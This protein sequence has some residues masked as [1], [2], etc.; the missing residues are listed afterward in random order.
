[1]RALPV[2][3]LFTVLAPAALGAP[4]SAVPNPP[5]MIAH[6][7]EDEVCRSGRLQRDDKRAVPK[8]YLSKDETTKPVIVLPVDR[9][10]MACEGDEDAPWIG[11]VYKRGSK[12]DF[13]HEG[14]NVYRKGHEET[15][16]AYDGPCLS[17]WVPRRFFKYL[18]G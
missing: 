13:D 8:L 14:C 17:G 15:K 11:V 2:V 18:A 1:V 12:K 6:W 9:L 7:S 4:K 16:F 10:V 3:V 5:V